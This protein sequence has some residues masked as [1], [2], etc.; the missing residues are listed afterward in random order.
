MNKTH[1][2][3]RQK[4]LLKL[5]RLNWLRKTF[6]FRELVVKKH[7]NTHTTRCYV[8]GQI[9]EKRS[10]WRV[11]PS[12]LAICHLSHRFLQLMVQ[13]ASLHSSSLSMCSPQLSCLHQSTSIV[14]S[15]D[16]SNHH[17]G[18]G[19]SKPQILPPNQT[20]QHP[21]KERS[22]ST[23]ADAFAGKI[24]SFFPPILLSPP[25]PDINLYEKMLLK[26]TARC[27]QTQRRRRVVGAFLGSSSPPIWFDFA[28]S[29]SLIWSPRARMRESKL[30]KAEEIKRCDRAERK[31]EL[32]WFSAF[33]FVFASTH[34]SIPSLPIS[35][36]WPQNSYKRTVKKLDQMN[37][38]T[39]E[40]IKENSPKLTHMPRQKILRSR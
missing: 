20:K 17:Q 30:T 23:A 11:I 1:T 14:R 34:P 15:F 26:H 18:Q 28:P 38:R 33:L 29:S 40:P 3:K 6:G 7:S 35:I 27:S 13:I 31:N 9:F 8:R 37:E 25:L 16:N 19:A 10:H 2:Y 12:E 24:P 32:V 4:I 36:Q 5:V 21:T 39:N 22:N